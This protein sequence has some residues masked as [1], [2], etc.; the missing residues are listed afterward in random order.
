MN[1][2]FIDTDYRWGFH[3]RVF[4]SLRATFEI[5]KRM[6]YSCFQ[7]FVS[8]RSFTLPNY[9]TSDLLETGRLLK[10]RNSYLCIHGNLLYNL[11]GPIKYKDKPLYKTKLED[12]RK[13]LTRELDLGVGLGA[14]IV[15]HPGSWPDKEKGIQTISET[16]THCL[17]TKTSKSKALS[18]AMGISHAD[19]ISRRKIIL[20]NAAGGG[21]KLAVTLEEI[22]SMIKLVPKKLHSQVKV[23]ID[24]AHAFGAGL[25]KW[26][27]PKEVKRFYE[28]FDRVIGLEFLEVFHLNDSRAS[29]QKRYNAYFGSYKDVHEY[30]GEGYIFGVYSEDLELLP[31]T[32]NLEGLKEFFKQA[33]RR[34]IPVIG[35]PP[36]KTRFGEK[37]PG[38]SRDWRF[39]VNL[40]STTDHPLEY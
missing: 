33:W 24:T 5:Y 8:N 35:E 38:P 34:D 9:D 39:V 12:T 4:P 16:I 37:G 18:K 30:L 1:V 3:V 6:P 14:G 17:T 36:G 28:D 7:I 32:T 20:E 29:E 40:L 25:Y 19:F 27:D 22:S 23:C 21:T 15:V 11:C 2:T 31:D 26:G 13:C 10:E